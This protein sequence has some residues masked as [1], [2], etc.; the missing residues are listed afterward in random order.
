MAKKTAHGGKRSGAGRKTAVPGEASK[1]LG[2]RVPVKWIDTIAA[3]DPTGASAPGVGARE[4]LRRHVESK[5][6]T[7]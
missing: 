4:I 6:K 1:V 3:E 2:V 7:R 5:R